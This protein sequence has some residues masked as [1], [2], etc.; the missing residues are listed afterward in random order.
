[1]QKVV[2]NNGVNNDDPLL[3]RFYVCQFLFIMIDVEPVWLKDAS[4]AEC[5]ILKFKVK[6]LF[7][8]SANGKVILGRK[9]RKQ[10]TNVE[11][12]QSAEMKE[13]GAFLEEG[14]K[15]LYFQN[16]HRA[17]QIGKLS[18]QRR[19]PFSMDA[20][21]HNLSFFCLLTTLLRG[22]HCHSPSAHSH[23]DE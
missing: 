1:M 22:F 11:E 16:Q 9:K 23:Y 3:A 14:K 6:L 19:D 7:L 13:K 15:S 5:S 10:K 18:W 8:H 17:C 12:A 20:Y 2:V 21:P 4:H